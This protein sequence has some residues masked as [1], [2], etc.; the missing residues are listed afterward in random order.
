MAQVIMILWE[1]GHQLESA[2]KD[3]TW[4]PSMSRTRVLTAG[5]LCCSLNASK[6]ELNESWLE[7]STWPQVAGKQEV[8]ANTE[9]GTASW[10]G[11]TWVRR[12][13]CEVVGPG[14]HGSQQESSRSG[15]R[16]HTHWEMSLQQTGRLG[17]QPGSRVNLQAAFSVYNL[18]WALAQ[19]LT[20]ARQLLCY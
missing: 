7:I 18:C 19:S 4:Q 2:T 8:W 20:G 6:Y 1:T 17:V 14:K 5:Q 12:A 11:T 10:H 13:T 3:T 15:T 9:P 16:A